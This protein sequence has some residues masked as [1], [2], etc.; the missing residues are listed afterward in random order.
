SIPALY[1]SWATTYV[2]PLPPAAFSPLAKKKSISL[3]FF[4][5]LIISFVTFLPGFPKISPINSMFNVHPPFLRL[6][7][8]SSLIYFFNTPGFIF[9]HFQILDFLML[10]IFKILGGV[11]LHLKFYFTNYNL[12]I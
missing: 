1:N 2:I 11:K 7:R 12:F 10:I 8:I 5:L 9:A 4:S 3:S 6:N